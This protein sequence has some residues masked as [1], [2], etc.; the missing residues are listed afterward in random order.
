MAGS[1]TSRR[2]RIKQG[3]R[4]N[5]AG[6]TER[7]RLSVFRSNK[8]IYAQVIDDTTGKTLAAASSLSKDLVASGN[9]V[10]QSKAVGKLVAEKAVAAGISKVV[11]D[12]NGYL[13]HGRVKSLAEGAREGGLD[14]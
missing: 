2:E 5:L 4:K 12:R 1:K 8:G 13:Y 10:D 7:P 3:I 9:K 6:T 14:F 11:F